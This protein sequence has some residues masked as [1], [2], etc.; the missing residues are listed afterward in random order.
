MSG[1]FSEPVES[2]EPVEPGTSQPESAPSASQPAAGNGQSDPSDRASDDAGADRNSPVS[3]DGSPSAEYPPFPSVH[4]PQPLP[5]YQPFVNGPSPAY[6]APFPGHPGMPMPP[7]YGPQGAPVVTSQQRRHRP[8]V[9]GVVIA[10]AVA[11]VVGVVGVIGVG[12]VVLANVKKPNSPAPSVGSRVPPVFSSPTASASGGTVTLVAPDRIGTLSKG[13]DQSPA[14]RLKTS[15]SNSGTQNPFAAIYQDTAGPR[16]SVIVWG[17]VG[18]IFS[19]G[20]PHTQLNG[21]FVGW[22]NTMGG[23]GSLGPVSDVDPGAVGGVAQ[24]TDV[25]GLGITQA[26]CAWVGDRVLVAVLFNGLSS[27]QAAQQLPAILAAVVVRG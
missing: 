18:E 22:R 16:R 4:V 10:L 25:N 26:V 5:E 20:N 15:L 9:I 19:L 14:D 11:F 8:V 13:V 24:C 17:G 21:F 1:D 7:Y 12:A 23:H 6:G 27:E 3:A 2:V